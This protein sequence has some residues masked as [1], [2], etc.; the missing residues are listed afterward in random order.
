MDDWAGSQFSGSQTLAQYGGA[1]YV[2]QYTGSGNDPIKDHE[3]GVAAACTYNAFF[4]PGI[5]TPFAYVRAWFKFSEATAVDQRNIDDDGKITRESDGGIS[6][7]HDNQDSGTS[8]YPG[9]R[10]RTAPKQAPPNVQH[11][12]H[13]K[14]G[15]A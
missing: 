7:A 2:A 6:D 11:S 1:T 5:Q 8:L 12:V 10:L 4:P 15:V 13:F 3:V 9:R 14:F